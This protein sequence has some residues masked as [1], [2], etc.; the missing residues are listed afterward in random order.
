MHFVSDI[1]YIMELGTVKEAL[2]NFLDAAFNLAFAL[3]IITFAYMRMES[4]A[5]CVLMK[6]MV[7]QYFSINLFDDHQLCLIIYAFF[8]IATKVLKCMLMSYNKV[9]C[10]IRC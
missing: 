10:L 4:N 9:F 8:W 5:V 1:N 6:L 3:W 2:F 7:K